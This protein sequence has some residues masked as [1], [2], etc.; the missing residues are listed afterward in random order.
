MTFRRWAIL[1]KILRG[2]SDMMKGA[3]LLTEMVEICWLFACWFTFSI[4]KDIIIIIFGLTA[5]LMGKRHFA[6]NTYLMYYADSR[7]SYY[8]LYVDAERQVCFS[9]TFIKFIDLP[10]IWHTHLALTHERENICI[11]RSGYVWHT[12]SLLHI[13]MSK[14]SMWN[15]YARIFL[16]FI[17]AALSIPFRRHA[18]MDWMD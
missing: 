4:Q 16:C 5:I 17:Q 9:T 3:L 12:L 13:L 10:S 6:P 18:W 2:E 11:W 14:L 7:S 8:I 15:K 1:T